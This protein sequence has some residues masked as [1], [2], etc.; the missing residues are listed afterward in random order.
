MT[1]LLRIASRKQVARKSKKK[2]NKEEAAAQ[3]AKRRL[4][5]LSDDCVSVSE[6]E[7]NPT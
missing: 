1:S 5:S 6:L 7:R 4:V 3:E 2:M